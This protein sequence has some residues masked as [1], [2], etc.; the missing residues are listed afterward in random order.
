MKEDDHEA[1]QLDEKDESKETTSSLPEKTKT[2]VTSKHLTSRK[3]NS[4]QK[5]RKNDRDPLALVPNK[6]R[7]PIY[8]EHLCSFYR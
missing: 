7:N 6:V 3:K 4:N 1:K 8:F 5:E 2:E